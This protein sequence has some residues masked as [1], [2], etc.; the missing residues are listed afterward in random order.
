MLVTQCGKCHAS[1]A[2]KLRG[3][4]RLDSREGLRR[5]GDSGPAIVPGQPDESLLIR[6]IRYRDEE[7]RMPPKGKLPDAVVADFEAWVKMGA[8]RP[9]NRA[10][11]AL[12]DRPSD[13]S[14]Q[15]DGVLVVSAA[16]EVGAAAGEADRLAA[17]RRSTASSW[18]R[19]KP[20][21]S[22]RSPTPTGR[23]SSAG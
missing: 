18:R 21:G 1:T 8:P 23:G 13:R 15:G 9:A 2:E 16:E 22:P 5:G 11:P 19:S 10:S 12:A 7:L 6:A 4:L 14:R 20:A 3:G 17:R